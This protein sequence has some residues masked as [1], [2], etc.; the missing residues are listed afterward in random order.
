VYHDVVLRPDGKRG[1]YGVVH[2]RFEAV[3]VLPFRADEVL[4]VGQQRYPLAAYSWE[5]PGGGAAPGEDLAAAAHRELAEETGYRAE[6]LQPIANFSI[7]N[8]VSDA[9]CR[10]YLARDLTAGP[11]APEGSEQLVLRWLQLGRCLDMVRSGEIHDA[12]TQ[13]ALLRLAQETQC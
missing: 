10:V 6:T 9:Y 3:S 5:I 12:I 1:I 11:A 4:L 2:A 13:I 7:W 8:A